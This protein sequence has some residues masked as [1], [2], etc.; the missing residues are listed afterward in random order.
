MHKNT[1]IEIIG[2]YGAIAIISAYFLNSFSIISVTNI[3]YQLLNTT[4]AIGIVTVS[5]MKKNYQPMFLN[6]LWGIIGIVA[7]IK[8][9]V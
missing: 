4:G 5:Y 2:W 1:F 9:V 7:L 6:I 8:L 3:W